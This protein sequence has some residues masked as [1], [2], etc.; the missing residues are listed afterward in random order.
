MQLWA[1]AGTVEKQHLKGANCDI[2]FPATKTA[3]SLKGCRIELGAGVVRFGNERVENLRAVVRV[4]QGRDV[5]TQKEETLDC[6]CLGHH[7][8]IASSCQI[9]P[10]PREEVKVAASPASRPADSLGDDTKFAA[11]WGVDGEDAVGLSV[12]EL[13]N[14]QRFCGVPA[15]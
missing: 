3:K 5:L 14:N 1:I 6:V 11:T 12:I 13:T 8:Q 2:P 7:I 9:K 15:G 4:G 10:N